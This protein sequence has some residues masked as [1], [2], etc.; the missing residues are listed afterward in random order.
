MRRALLVAV[1]LLMS[2]G[3]ASPN[4]WAR[5]AGAAQAPAQSAAQPPSPPQVDDPAYLRWRQEYDAARARRKRG[6]T[7]MVAGGG[8]FG[9][10]LYLASTSTRSRTADGLLRQEEV[11]NRGRYI[12]GGAAILGSISMVVLGG[13]FTSQGSGAMRRLEEEGRRRRYITLGPS[14]EGIGV[15][16]AFSF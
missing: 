2:C 13:R 10:G 3:M 1:I 14:T 11:T 16:L 8:L 4:A 15:R 7:L 6:I 12:A 9:T 5:V